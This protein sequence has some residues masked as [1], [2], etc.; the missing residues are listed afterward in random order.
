MAVA[1]IPAGEGVAM[2]IAKPLLWIVLYLLA[3]LPASLPAQQ[4]SLTSSPFVVPVGLEPA[5]EFWKR[6]FSEFGRSQLIFFDP[7]DMSKIYEVIEVGEDNRTD[8]Y[9]DGERA[10]I[11][12][13]N[14]VDIERVRAQRG[15]KERNAAGIKSSGR[16]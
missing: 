1:V 5:V 16:G 9:I 3:A 14:G 12:A 4:V 10:R 7:L 13:A 8:A 2:R 6:V 15:I 11:A